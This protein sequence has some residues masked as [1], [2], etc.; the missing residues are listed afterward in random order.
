MT[1]FIILASVMCLFF[2]SFCFGSLICIYKMF[3]EGDKQG[4][5]ILLVI[6][7]TVVVLLF[8]YILI[9]MFI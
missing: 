3:K 9:G 6:I 8:S 2:L 4:A 5:T 1:G 7:I